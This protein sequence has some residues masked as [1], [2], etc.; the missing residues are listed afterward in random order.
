L[1]IIGGTPAADDLMVASVRRRLEVMSGGR[2]LP[3]SVITLED[4]LARTALAS[5][6]IAGVLVGVLAAIALILGTLGI[7]GALSE[8]ARQRRREFAVRIALG[9]QRARVVRQILAAGLR[10]AVI[11]IVVGVLGA[12]LVARWLAEVTQTGDPAPLWMWLAGPLL[13]LMAVVAASVLPARR[14][15]MVNPLTIMRDS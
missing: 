3:G 14:A 5:E 10:L 12:L 11:A 6:R 9:A 1:T 2:L 13:L 4:Q 7:Y 8:F 15:M